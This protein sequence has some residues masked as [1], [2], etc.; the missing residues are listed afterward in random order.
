MKILMTGFTSLQAQAPED[1]GRADIRKLDVP[2]MIVETL[3]AQG[4]DIDW[5]PT[6]LGENLARYDV[7][8]INLAPATSMNSR[9]GMI[10]AAY[11]LAQDVPQ[12]RFYDDW[13][14]SATTS[15]GKSIALHPKRIYKR[16]TDT[17]VFLYKEY[18]DREL[19]ESWESTICAGLYSLSWDG[20]REND[21]HRY[22]I[23]KFGYWGDLQTVI[24]RMPPGTVYP[25]DPTPLVKTQVPDLGSWDLADTPKD[26]EWMLAS[27][28]PHMDWADA[29]PLTWPIAGYGTRKYKWERLK[30]ENDVLRENAKR[31]GILSPKYA[32][33][34]S[35]WFRARYL[36][37]ASGGSVI[38]ADPSDVHA[39]G[40]A[41]TFNLEEMQS[42]TDGQ[43][44]ELAA[45]QRDAMLNATWRKTEWAQ[46]IAKIVS[47]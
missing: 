41:Y 38:Y 9:R 36:Y 6:L 42:Y 14:F 35:G 25:I 27:V 39:L 12:V 34:G 40:N 32:H 45:A 44:H 8:W 19:V 37:A 11:A 28:M 20:Y 2:L 30:T 16:V 26:R 31:W 3:R 18:A 24:D 46:A 21:A 17:D 29:L 47:F 23:P 43:L 15:A 7:V 5:R 10:G 1:R 33:A 4:H 13:Q 22:V